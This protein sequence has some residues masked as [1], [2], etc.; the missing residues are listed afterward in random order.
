MKNLFILF[1]ILPSLLVFSQRDFKSKNPLRA[2]PNT[3]EN[4]QELGPDFRYM[5]FKLSKIETEETAVSLQLELNQNSNFGKVEIVKT[6]GFYGFVRKDFV[7]QLES[8]FEAKGLVVIASRSVNTL[9][10]IEGSRRIIIPENMKPVYQ[11]TGN[12]KEDKQRYTEAKKQLLIEHPEYI[13]E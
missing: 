7:L 8:F 10:P 4:Q 12:P 1:L 5:Q 3:V 13:Q 6:Y 11:D 9:A 2:N